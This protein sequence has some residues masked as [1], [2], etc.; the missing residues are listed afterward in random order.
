MHISGPWVNS[1]QTLGIGM[2][3]V[4]TKMTSIFAIKNILDKYPIEK[5][6]CKTK[7]YIAIC[8][9]LVKSLCVR[10]RNEN[11]QHKIYEIRLQIK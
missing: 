3:I 2:R 8:Y 4:N 10:R 9:L 1:Y 11:V 7:G 6:K 5:K